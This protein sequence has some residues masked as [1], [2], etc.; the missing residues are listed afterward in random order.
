MRHYRSCPGLR[1][2]SG[3]RAKP[4]AR[5]KPGTPLSATQFFPGSIKS[6]EPLYECQLP[7]GFDVTKQ[8]WFPLLIP[9]GLALSQFLITIPTWLDTK[10]NLD[11]KLIGVALVSEWTFLIL[12]PLTSAMVAIS[13][14]RSALS[15]WRY[16]LAFLLPSLPNFVWQV[17]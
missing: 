3:R 16:Y 15:W 10:M 6:G 14:S 1:S 17:V 12:L 13:F 2:R 8:P 9:F 4:T 5:S 7:R 11:S